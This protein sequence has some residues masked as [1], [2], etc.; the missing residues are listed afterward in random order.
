MIL[1]FCADLR[2]D[3]LQLNK[4][5]PLVGLTVIE[6]AAIGPAPFCGMLLADLGADVIVIDRPPKGDA[7]GHFDTLRGATAVIGRG[8]RSLALDLK[9]PEAV[10]VL[11]QLIESADAV[12]EGFRPGVMERLGLGPEVCQQRNPALVYGRMTGWGQNGPLAQFAGHDINY[13]ALTGALYSMGTADRP[14]LPP[15][16]LVGD[17]GGGGLM[18]AFGIVCALLDAQRS[19][20]GQVVDAAMS[21]GSATLMAM[22][23]GLLAE[24]S[25]SERRGENFLDGSAPFY[26][27]YA[28]ADGGYVAV[29]AIEPQ[30]Y[31][32]LLD[33][34]GVQE[35][36]FQ[37]QWNREHWP[38]LQTRLAEVF[39][40]QPRQHW[41]E[42]LE[43]SDACFAPVLSMREAPQ[44]PHNIARKVFV[45][46][47]GLTQPAPS[48]R[49]SRTPGQ[50]QNLAPKAGE[51]SRSIL[52]QLGLAQ[53]KIDVLVEKGVV[54]VD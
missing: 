54:H 42:L 25:W 22:L 13:I 39:G 32:L 34:L 19:G 28:C 5:G 7:G 30:F 17:Y 26:T 46:V 47:E 51:N 15:L 6:M 38:A 20:Q 9:K 45:E 4:T 33:R 53:H 52:Q 41:C 40:S 3:I 36:V 23:Y 18:L 35:P 2:S 21:D 1:L 31:K 14:P 43:D 27:T 11:L 29:G 48:P 37:Q 50:V 10:E 12:I 16:N 24:Q 8:R 49:F 44:H